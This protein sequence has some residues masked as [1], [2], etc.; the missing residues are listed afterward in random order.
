MTIVNLRLHA[1]LAA[2]IVLAAV[3]PAGMTC[4][5][6]YPQSVVNLVAAAKKAVQ[7]ISMAEFKA[8]YDRN[9]VGLLIDVR[10]PGEY[11]AGYPVE[12]PE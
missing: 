6:D 4:G 11:A 9:D 7:P 12:L 3:F 8:R 1:L 2:V 5:A 10:D